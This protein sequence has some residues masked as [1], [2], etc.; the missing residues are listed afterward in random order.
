MLEGD[1]TDSRSQLLLGNNTITLKNIW[2][3]RQSGNVN[4]DLDELHGGPL[5]TLSDPMQ[6]RE[7]S[8][9]I[10]MLPMDGDSKWMADAHQFID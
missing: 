1:M 10:D 9:T 3:M 6:S 4:D 5:R 8:V 2:V 7:K